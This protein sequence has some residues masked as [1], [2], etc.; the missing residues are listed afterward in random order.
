MSVSAQQS[1]VEP[2]TQSP[3]APSPPVADSS[4]SSF[5]AAPSEPF[6][7]VLPVA[8]MP[9]FFSPAPAQQFLQN[10]LR[11][12]PFQLYPHASYS[13]T[14][15]TGLNRAP[16]QS[17]ESLRHTIA[18]GLTWRA[19]HVTVDYTP[20]LTYYT[21]GDFGDSVNHSVSL[22]AG[23]GYGDWRFSLSHRYSTGSA[24]LAE[25]ARQTE[26][27]T[28]STSL[29]ANYQYSEKTSFSFSLVQRIY[30]TPQFNS[31][32]TWS[33]MNWANYRLTEKVTVGTGVGGGFTEMESGSNMTYEQLQAR[34]GWTPGPKLTLHVNG[35]I[36]IRQFVSASSI[37]DQV[38]PIFG[39]SASYQ[40]FEPTTISLNANRAI[41]PSLL[42]G[43]TSESTSVSAGVTQR[44]LGRLNLGVNAGYRIAEYQATSPTAGTARSDESKFVSASLS[45]RLFQKGSIGVAYSHN[46]HS[47][48]DRD[49]SFESDQY[50]FHLGYHF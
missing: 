15:A 46:I 50:T 38:N 41:S 42:T 45:T 12:G 29:G 17:A 40:L 43:Q 5:Y 4:P 20:S 9:G 24:I 8:G 28:H 18:P 3:V 39:A 27:E 26:F 1:E 13:M 21:K 35:G 22:Q 32:K 44:L 16:G 37:G 10:P 36:D 47:S 49:F 2:V 33:S 34:L 6:T 30:E 11:W 7:P 23:Y 19:P 31:S 48:S 14:Y 25:T